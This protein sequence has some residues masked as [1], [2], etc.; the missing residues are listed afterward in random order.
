MLDFQIEEDVPQIEAFR[1]GA[2][3]P[4]EE[5]AAPLGR[6]VRRGE[7]Q[8]GGF[9]GEGEMVV[10]R[11]TLH[12]S[13]DKGAGSVWGVESGKEEGGVVLP[14]GGNLREFL[15]GALEEGVGFLGGRD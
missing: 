3:E 8:L 12:G 7:F 1:E 5:S 15:E 14:E 9:H 4:F 10:L 2:N 11:Q 13:G 6:S